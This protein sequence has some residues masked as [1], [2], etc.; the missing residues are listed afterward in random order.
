MRGGAWNDNPYR[1][2]ELAGAPPFDRSAHNG[3]RCA[4]YPEPDGI[5][6]SAFAMATFGESVDYYKEKPVSEAIFQ[7][8]KEQ[9]LYDETDLNA[10]LETRDESSEYWI[11][12]RISFDAAY[13]NER[14]I[15]N[16][17]LP[18]NISPPIKPSSI[19]P[20]LPLYSNHRAKTLKTIMNS[21]FFFPFW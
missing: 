6:K 11:Y 16:L 10:R 19:S 15:A 17:C 12:E 4:L 9:F 5:P 1:F 7:V 3:F 21:R 18:K 8:Y 20:A 14:I 13:G 2:T